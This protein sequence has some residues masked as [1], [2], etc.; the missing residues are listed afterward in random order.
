MDAQGH[1]KAGNPEVVSSNPVGL[2]D[3]PSINGETEPNA[4]H[5][6]V[7]AQQAPPVAPSPNRPRTF[8]EMQNEDSMHGT[9]A[10]TLSPR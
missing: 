9:D 7:R 3:I 5:L 1:L 2:L 6:P 8:S 10:L 4:G